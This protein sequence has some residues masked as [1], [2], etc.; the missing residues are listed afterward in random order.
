MTGRQLGAAVATLAVLWVLLEVGT[1]YFQLSYVI[2]G[3]AA[4][5]RF[6]VNPVPAL[7]LSATAILAFVH[8]RRRMMTEA[9][10]VV[11]VVAAACLLGGGLY[12]AGAAARVGAPLRGRVW[13]GAALAGAT[14]GGW[15]AISVQAWIVSLALLDGA[16]PYLRL[17]RAVLALTALAACGLLWTIG[18]PD[19][20]PWVLAL[21]LSWGIVVAV[22]AC[23]RDAFLR[24]DPERFRF[25]RWERE[26]R[27]YELVGVGAFRWLLRHTP[28]GWMNP[29]LKLTSCRSGIDPLLREMSYAE[30]AHVAGGALTLAVA[31]GYAAAGHGSVGLALAVLTIPVHFYPVILQRWNRGRV[32]RVIRHLRAHDEAARAVKASSA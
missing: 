3:E 22:A 32:A 6:G 23:T 26:G 25:A 16:Q 17:R 5:P 8:A 1:D 7:L 13:L 27:V 4:R 29:T 19:S 31:A 9:R 28:L 15:A 12:I 21:S 2:P 24:M 30:G 18:R 20:H 14:V 10:S 11:G